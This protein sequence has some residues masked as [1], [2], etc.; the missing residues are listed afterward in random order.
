MSRLF[1]KSGLK[2]KPAN[3]FLCYSHTDRDT[4]HTLYSRL[5]KDGVDVWLDS[6]KL[7]PGQDWEHEI[8]AAILRS[9]AVIV[10]LSRRFNRQK[11]YRHEELK[12]ALEKA[13]SLHDNEIFIIPARLESCD[14]PDSLR[15]LHRV[16]LFETDGYKKLMKALRKRITSM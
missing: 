8:R 14:T 9:Q 12:I 15:H 6:E 3:V 13:E 4:V 10:C 1:H 2:N 11:G 7:L 16:D 5:K